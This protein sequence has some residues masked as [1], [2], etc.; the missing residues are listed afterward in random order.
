NND[1]ASFRVYT[2]AFV[3]PGFGYTATSPPPV[4]VNTM[5]SAL[6]RPG[7][8]GGAQYDLALPFMWNSGLPLS[9]STWNPINLTNAQV[10]L[11]QEVEDVA[12]I[13]PANNVIAVN[14]IGHS[15]GS[16][17]VTGASQL[18]GALSLPQQL[19]DGYCELTLLDPHPANNM[20]YPS[21]SRSPG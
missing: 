2:V 7:A 19:Q 9:P 10:G 3:V 18:L 6:E 20:Y 1:T 13:V 5:I 16:E 21:A 11:T 4:W 15:R 17:V 8:Q 14:L 12:S